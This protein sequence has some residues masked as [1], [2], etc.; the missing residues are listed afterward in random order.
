[1]K[2]LKFASGFILSAMLI[3]GFGVVQTHASTVHVSSYSHSVN[4][5]KEKY[6]RQIKEFRSIISSNNSSMNGMKKELTGY[7]ELGKSNDDRALFSLEEKVVKEGKRNSTLSRNVSKF[8]KDVKAQKNTKKD[9]SLSKTSASLR[10]QL[11]ALK[12]E[13]SKTKSELTRVGKKKKAEIQ[14]K[15]A[16]LFLTKEADEQLDAIYNNKMKI[17][18]MRDQINELLTTTPSQYDGDLK[19]IDNQLISLFKNYDDLKKQII[20]VRKKAESIKSTSPVAKLHNDIQKIN[21]KLEQLLSILTEGYS[22]NLNTI[23][24][25][26]KEVGK[27]RQFEHYMRHYDEM[28][29]LNGKLQMISTADENDA[30]HLRKLLHDR[31]VAFQELDSVAWRYFYILQDYRTRNY[32]AVEDAYD[33][34]QNLSS[35]EDDQA[36]AAQLTLVNGLMDIFISNRTVFAQAE[37]EVILEKY[38]EKNN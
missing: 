38:S 11:V 12:K 36:F 23:V 29:L 1:M 3:S 2:G 10:K 14:L 13:I 33:K 4:K 24:D 31:G 30:D 37:K 9:Y 32:E 5:M 28:N 26:V 17:Q 34:L 8:E 20:S 27:E 15:I 35:H 22:E 18:E 25:Q 7:E 6:F 21:G 19:K 16:K